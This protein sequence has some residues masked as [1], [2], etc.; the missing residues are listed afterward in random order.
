MKQQTEKNL[1]A[2]YSGGYWTSLR[3][4][5]VVCGTCVKGRVQEDTVGYSNL[6]K[7][8]FTYPKQNKNLPM[9]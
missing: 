6:T 7:L 9:P 2:E 5:I 1:Q 8:F 4:G 3:H